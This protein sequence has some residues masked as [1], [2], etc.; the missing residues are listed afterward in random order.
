MVEK[1][2]CQALRQSDKVTCYDQTQIHLEIIG[3]SSDWQI[4]PIDSFGDCRGQSDSGLPETRWES[5]WLAFFLSCKC[6][7]HQKFVWVHIWPMCKAVWFSTSYYKKTSTNSSS[8][9][10]LCLIFMFLSNMTSTSLCYGYLKVAC[11]NWG[12]RYP[13]ES[14]KITYW[15]DKSRSHF[16]SKCLFLRS[17]QIEKMVTLCMYSPFQVLHFP[18]KLVQA[19]KIPENL[20]VNFPN[21][22]I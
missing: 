18:M 2:F 6:R 12:P 22:L 15:Y 21:K 14:L 8:P 11:M 20:L 4:V 10:Y 16:H 5:R 19:Q 1:D 3:K 7:W 17:L 9:L 13:P